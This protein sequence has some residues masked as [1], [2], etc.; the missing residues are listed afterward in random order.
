M[1]TAAASPLAEQ[2]D[3]RIVDVAIALVLVLVAC[4]AG[5]MLSVADDMGTYNCEYCDLDNPADPMNQMFI[6]STINQ[7]V[8][9]WQPGDTVTIT[10]DEG[11]SITFEYQANGNFLAIDATVSW[12]WGNFWAWLWGSCFGT[13]FECMGG[14]GGGGHAPM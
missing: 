5:T 8:N 13:F 4:G 11:K 1:S 2:Q 6:T 14:H 12:T 3:V 9:I 7:H 10:D